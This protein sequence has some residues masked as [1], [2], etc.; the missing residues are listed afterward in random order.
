LCSISRTN[1]P[2]FSPCNVQVAEPSV[3]AYRAQAATVDYGRTVLNALHE[4]DGALTAYAEEQKRRALI[5][6]AVS[7]NCAGAV[8]AWAQ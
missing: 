1:A 6:G 7:Q 5:A 8:N 4:V 3:A 2:P